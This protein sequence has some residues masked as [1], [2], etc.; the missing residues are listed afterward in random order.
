MSDIV[1]IVKVKLNLIID[2]SAYK[3]LLDLYTDIVHF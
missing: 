2:L 3:I 1:I